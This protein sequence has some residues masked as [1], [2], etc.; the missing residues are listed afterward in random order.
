VGLQQAIALN[1]VRTAGLKA[2]FADRAFSETVPRGHVVSTDPGPGDQVLRGGTVT[3]VVSKGKERYP[4]PDLVGTSLG[5]ASAMLRHTHLKPGGL[6]R[7]YSTK[8]A[9]DHVI[10]VSPDPGT[11]VKRDTEV[12]LVVSRGP[13]PVDV[14]DLRNDSGDHAV[15]TLHGLGLEASVSK[16][17]SDTVPQGQVVSQDPGGGTTVGKGSTVSLVVSRGPQLFEVPDVRGQQAD[18]AVQT[19]KSDGFKPSVRSLPG[20][21]GRVL[22]QSPGGGDKQ[23][24]GTTV[25]LYVF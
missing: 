16:D 4:V 17:Y 21:P 20:G 24:H 19:L 2:Q 9:K 8:I 18:Q 11:R 13:Q 6:N 15:A 10:A 22:N 3:M 23:P 1:H 25:T 7:K 12:R 5:K 14:P